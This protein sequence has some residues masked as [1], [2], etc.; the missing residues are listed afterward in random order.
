[1]TAPDDRTVGELQDRLIESA[2]TGQP[3][4]G[5]GSPLRLPDVGMVRRGGAVR[6][7]AD[8]YLGS[9]A[10]LPGVQVIGADD[11]APGAAALRFEVTE[12]RPDAV[13]INLEVVGVPPAGQRSLTPLGRAQVSFGRQPD[14]W[15]VS[16]DPVYL[17]T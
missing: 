12:R 15:Q 10:D 11:V 13:G 1:M 17:A 14:G 9:A 4:P 8:G 3:L 2:L 16:G 5:L 7:V 6:V